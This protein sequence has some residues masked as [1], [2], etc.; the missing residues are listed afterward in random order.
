[1]KYEGFIFKIKPTNKFLSEYERLKDLF[2]LKNYKIKVYL[3]TCILGMTLDETIKQEDSSPLKR[4]FENK[5][6]IIE[7]YTSEKTKE[8]MSKH[9]NNS[10]K[11]Y[12]HFIIS[13]FDVIPEENYIHTIG[14]SIGSLSLG[15][16]PLGCGIEEDDPLFAKLKNI[17][18][19]DDAKHIFQAIKSE[20]KYFLTTDSKTI[21]SRR[22]EFNKLGFK[23]KL[24]SPKNLENILFAEE[25]NTE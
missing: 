10:K 22:K 13:F 18:D 23:I 15:S 24:V 14:G 5:K 8:E 1:M 9:A 4:I 12:L 3:D 11:D 6:E 19:L 7:P 20:A 21:L 25:D 17:F 16:A 2:F